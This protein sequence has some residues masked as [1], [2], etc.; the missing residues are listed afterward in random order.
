MTP[1]IVQT[2]NACFLS[3]SLSF[4]QVDPA[5]LPHQKRCATVAAKLY[6]LA[7]MPRGAPSQSEHRRELSSFSF[8]ARRIFSLRLSNPNAPVIQNRRYFA[9]FGSAP[10][11]DYLFQLNYQPIRE[12]ATLGSSH[13]LQCLLEFFRDRSR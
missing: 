3:D 6:A 9:Y 13:F 11:L 1:R 2:R 5:A 10:A 7:A 4:P 12:A 8:L